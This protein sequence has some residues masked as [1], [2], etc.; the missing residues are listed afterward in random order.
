[1]AEGWRIGLGTLRTTVE[2][3]EASKGAR[4]HRPCCGASYG[5]V[6]DRDQFSASF[7]ARITVIRLMFRLLATALIDAPAASCARAAAF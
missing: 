5:V 7:L 3:S 1:M 6:P 4:K 2:G